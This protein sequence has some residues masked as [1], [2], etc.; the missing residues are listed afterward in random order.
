MERD[1]WKKL[2]GFWNEKKKNDSR[3]FNGRFWFFHGKINTG[4]LIR[5]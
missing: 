5:A 4:Y 3:F 2:M 1:F